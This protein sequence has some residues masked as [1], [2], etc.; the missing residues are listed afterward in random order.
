MG[1]E[2]MPLRA[3]NMASTMQRLIFTNKTVKKK[4][5]KSRKPA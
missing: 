5:K 4:A 1:S 2:N 3:E